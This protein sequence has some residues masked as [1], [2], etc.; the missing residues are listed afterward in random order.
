[1][2]T[3][4]LT[5]TND[6]T[7]WVEIMFNPEV[8]NFKYIVSE[9]FIQTL[10]SQYPYYRRNAAVNFREFQLTGLIAVDSEYIT[11]QSSPFFTL[12][13][14]NETDIIKKEKLYRD[15]VSEFLRNGQPKYYESDTEGK[16]KVILSDISFT[17]N[18]T[19]G[20]RLYSFSVKVTEIGEAES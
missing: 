2:S 8:T 10:G 15:A 20:R 14:R 1:M 16:I 7:Q 13:V 11:K 18:K 12:A 4:K 5:A 17:P 19:L 6:L 3:I 9:G